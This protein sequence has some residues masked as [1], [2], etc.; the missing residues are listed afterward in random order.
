MFCMSMALQLHIICF[1]FDGYCVARPGKYF[2]I[3]Q[4][5]AKSE[6]F[7][8]ILHAK[9]KKQCTQWR[10]SEWHLI[11]T[12]TRNS[13]SSIRCSFSAKALN[14]PRKINDA[15]QQKSIL[16]TWRQNF[17][18]L[19]LWRGLVKQTLNT[20]LE[21]VWN[22]SHKNTW[23]ITCSWTTEVWYKHL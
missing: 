9:M 11:L 6:Q 16:S 20:G 14:R 19:H 8:K 4:V 12:A 13:E 15:W 1:L 5:W 22:E 23:T 2:I 17:S 18:S 21:A 7:S 3:L 10:V